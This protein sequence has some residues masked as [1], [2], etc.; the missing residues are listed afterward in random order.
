MPSAPGDSPAPLVVE[1]QTF[2][3]E[4]AAE[5]S[6][7]LLDWIDVYYEVDDPELAVVKDTGSVVSV[8]NESEIEYTIYYTNNGQWVAENVVLTE[9]LPENT[10][11]VGGPEWQQ[12]DSS[13]IYIRQVGNIGHGA[14]GNTTFRVRVADEVELIQRPGLRADPNLSMNF[15]EI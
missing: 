1:R 13:N 2:C 6:S 12:V 10:A 7:P 3:R 9:T 11:Y 14:S 4:F 5:N 15:G 8:T